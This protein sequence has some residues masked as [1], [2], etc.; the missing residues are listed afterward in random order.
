MALVQEQMS[1]PPCGLLE[2]QSRYTCPD[3]TR[4]A[5]AG[6]NWK[7]TTGKGVGD[8]VAFCRE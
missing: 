5:A 3:T 6:T 1:A 8:V 2:S 4:A 7:L